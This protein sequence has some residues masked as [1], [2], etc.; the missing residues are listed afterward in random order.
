MVLYYFQHATMNRNIFFIFTVLVL[1]EIEFKRYMDQPVTR[2]KKGMALRVSS[3]H[4]VLLGIL[5][6]YPLNPYIYDHKS[7]ILWAHYISFIS[8]FY[9]F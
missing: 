8:S 5:R 1:L 3:F 2:T 9:K 6:Y 7:I 4:F